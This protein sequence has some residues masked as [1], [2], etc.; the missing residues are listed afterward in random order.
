MNLFRSEEHI[1]RW[2]AGR[3]PGATMTLGKLSELAHAW[4]R[5]R[6]DQNWRPHT[7][8]Q[9]QRILDG[10]GLTGAFWRLPG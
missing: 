7:R 8:G 3:E 6:L 4:Y 5:D 2:L 10:L 1:T 9:N